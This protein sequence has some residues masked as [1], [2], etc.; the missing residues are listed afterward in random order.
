MSSTSGLI[1]NTTTIDNMTDNFF[2]SYVILPG[3][4]TLLDNQVIEL[5]KEYLRIVIA[6][7][8]NK[9]LDYSVA[10]TKLKYYEGQPLHALEIHI[11]NLNKFNVPNYDETVN[12]ITNLL[13]LRPP[14]VIY[15][16]YEKDMNVFTL[17]NINM[18]T[19]AILK[20]MK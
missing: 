3:Q 12:L 20:K 14:S 10:Q 2:G 11:D 19:I 8:P 17:K 5:T 4:Y 9:I 16:T 7:T 13:Y 1:I 6:G 18:A 15:M